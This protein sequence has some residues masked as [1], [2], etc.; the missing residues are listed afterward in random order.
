M[1][2]AVKTVIYAGVALVVALVAAITYPRQEDFEPP[3]L[4]GKPLFEGFTNPEDATELRIV[5]F[6]EDVGELTEFEVARDAKTG[7]WVIPS[8]SDY[9][10]DAGSQMLAAATS[11]IDLLVLEWHPR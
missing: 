5:N 11:L 4:V 10:A 2:E 6:Q 3:D 7:L 9:P 1:N 8:S